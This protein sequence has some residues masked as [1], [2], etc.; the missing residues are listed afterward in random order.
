MGTS[1]LFSSG[2]TGAYFVSD[3]FDYGEGNGTCARFNPSWPASSPHVTAVGGTMLQKPAAGADWVEVACSIEA[4]A[5]IT[6]G[7]GF[8]NVYDRPA[9]QT[10]AVERYLA[11]TSGLPPA[12]S[13]DPSKRGFPDLS[14]LAHYIA[15]V[16]GGEPQLTGGTSASAPLVAG[17]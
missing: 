9:Y 5:W 2:D 3:P 7:G 16:Q 17:C 11:G 1:V 13:F 6:S 12:G 15:V 14:A 10:A 8:S 4:G